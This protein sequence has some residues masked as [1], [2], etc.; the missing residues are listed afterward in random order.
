MHFLSRINPRFY[1]PVFSTYR[2]DV[3]MSYK[4]A[5]WEIQHIC[6]LWDCNS[7]HHNEHPS[8]YSENHPDPLER[9]LHESPDVE[10]VSWN[11]GNPQWYVGLHTNYALGSA[12][13]LLRQVLGEALQPNGWNRNDPW[14]RY[15]FAEK[16][17]KLGMPHIPEPETFY[18]GVYHL[19]F[20]SLEELQYI[21]HGNNFYAMCSFAIA[22][23][24]DALKLTR[25]NNF[26]RAGYM[27]GSP[28]FVAAE[29][30][31]QRSRGLPNTEL[32]EDDLSEAGESLH[33]NILQKG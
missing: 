8:P 14:R 3:P 19:P 5:L 21:V 12:Y 26:V 31:W 22:D 10:L 23:I 30:R 17:T 16:L 24:I 29:C 20:D 15:D 13:R 4:T 33:E 9:R 25:F 27:R 32:S 2:N 1:H 28:G 11:H 6:E 18:E 7:D